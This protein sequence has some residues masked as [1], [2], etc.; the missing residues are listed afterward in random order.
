MKPF[1]FPIRRENGVVFIDGAVDAAFRKALLDGVP[2]GLRSKMREA[3]AATPGRGARGPALIDTAAR[4]GRLPCKAAAGI[5]PHHKF[6][7]DVGR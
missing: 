3:L 7:R 5:G 6:D 2:A 4:M 1:P